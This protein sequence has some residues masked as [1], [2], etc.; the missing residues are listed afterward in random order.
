MFDIVVTT[1]FGLETVVSR[2]M[3]ALGFDTYRVENGKITI[4]AGFE[5]ISRLNVWL[6][7]ADRVFIKL[8]SFP[9]HDFGEL[10]DQARAIDWSDFFPADARIDVRGKSHQSQLHSVPDC[11]A[12]VKK[13]IIEQL[14]SAYGTTW[15]P[16]TGPAFPLEVALHKD[17]ANLLLDTSGTGLHKRGYRTLVG[18]APLKETLA[19]GL[20][21]LSFWNADR[22]LIDP[23]CGSGTI[24]IEAA[25]IGLNR[26]PGLNRSFA[27]EAWPFFP[28]QIWSQKRE[29]A[30]DLE[31]KDR[32]F[33]IIGNDSDPKVLELARYHAR[34]AGVDHL[35]HFQEQS[36]RHLQTKKKYGCLITNPPYGE[37]LGNKNDLITLY[38]EMALAFSSLETWSIYILSADPDFSTYFT[39]K[40][41]KRRKLYNGKIACTYFEFF[42]P[43]PPR[44][45]SGKPGP[46]PPVST[47]P[48]VAT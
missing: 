26:A 45:S 41:D 20:V 5:E 28:G 2:E 35:I 7:S 12:I 3:N 29:E 11:Q 23:F 6:R 27:A 40:A 22:P 4:Q 33:H 13:A 48:S 8:A 30:R 32:Q 39:R 34:Q 37:R 19:A 44:R 47:S 25:L 31:Q 18:S 9:A 15:F 36:V 21:K 46:N 1:A 14:K 17:E 42:G 43:A 38:Q 16:E 10:F 24:P